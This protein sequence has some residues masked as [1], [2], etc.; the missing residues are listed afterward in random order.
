M[1]SLEL[2]GYFF[3]VSGMVNTNKEIVAAP[4]M[5]ACVKLLKRPELEEI[6]KIARLF[7]SIRLYLDHMKSITQRPVASVFPFLNEFINNM[8][9]TE[10][11]EYI[12]TLNRKVFVAKRQSTGAK[13]VVKFTSTYN[14][15]IHSYC[16]SKGYAPELMFYKE[17]SPN[18]VLVVM[19]F[20]D[21][22]EV[23]ESDREDVS[24]CGQAR[25]FLDAMREKRYVHGDL[26]YPNVLI[27]NTDNKL[28]I[29]DFDWAGDHNV[30]E[31]SAMMNTDEI[32][33]PHGAEPEEKMLMEHDEYWMKMH[34]NIE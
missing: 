4:F 10:K 28:Q 29:I 14:V 31:Y 20:I 15:I 18:L 25:H 8:G 12:E 13:V 9:Q 24:I 3:S 30:N 17:L 6:Y 34:F 32:E 26:R 19:D 11:L 33:W 16:H 22:R 7:K 21:A 27:T 2:E 1:L 5:N 23:H